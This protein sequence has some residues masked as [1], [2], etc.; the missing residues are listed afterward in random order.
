M[1]IGRVVYELDLPASLASFHLIFHVSI[2]KKYFGDH[3]LVFPIDKIGFMDSLSYEEVP[4]AI[5][6]WKVQKLMSKE[7][8]SVNCYG[9]IKR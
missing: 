3:A 5:L 1:R 8:A 7:I 6:D 4:I 9:G 2:L